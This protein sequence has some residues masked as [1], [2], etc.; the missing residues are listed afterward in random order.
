MQVERESTFGCEYSGERASN[1]FLT[2][3][4]VRDST[5]KLVVIPDDPD[6]PHGWSGKGLPPRDRGT[7]YQ[8]VG[9]VTAH[10]GADG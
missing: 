3:P 10:Q 4:E 9:E 8:L 5:G 2:C 1:A 7:S 6:W